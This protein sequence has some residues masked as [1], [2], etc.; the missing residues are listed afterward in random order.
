MI[1]MNNAMEIAFWFW[2]RSICFNDLLRFGNI[3]IRMGIYAWTSLHHS[4]R[5]TV[6]LRSLQEKKD[7]RKEFE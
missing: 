2:K 4:F 3:W 1:L 6:S 5:R 7:G